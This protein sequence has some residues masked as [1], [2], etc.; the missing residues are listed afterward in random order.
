[1]VSVKSSTSIQVSWNPP[2]AELQNG[3]ITEYRIS[4][5]ELDTGRE[6]SYVSVTTSILIQ[7]LHPSYT[8]ECTVSAYTVSEGPYSETINVMMLEDGE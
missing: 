5:V 7:F 1:M 8:Y 6:L 4:L 3:Q 2:L